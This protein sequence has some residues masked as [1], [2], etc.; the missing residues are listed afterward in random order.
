MEE[1]NA[2]PAINGTAPAADIFTGDE[3]S[4]EYWQWKSKMTGMCLMAWSSQS[5]SQKAGLIAA[6]VAGSASNVLWGGLT[7]EETESPYLTPASVFAQLTPTYGK[8]AATDE[9]VIADL[10]RLRQDGK[11]AQKYTEEF[12]AVATKGKL[13]DGTRRGLYYGG[14][15]KR[16]RTLMVGKEFD[17]LSSMIETAHEIDDL[18]DK[19]KAAPSPNAGRGRGGFRGRGRGGR[20]GYGA[21]GASEQEGT[22]DQPYHTCYACNEKGHRSFNCPKNGGGAKGTT[23]G[24]AREAST[25]SA[26]Y[27]QEDGQKAPP[28]YDSSTGARRARAYTP[29]H[30]DFDIGDH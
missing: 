22:G 11:R 24:K 2:A 15:A 8:K 25:S 26:Q 19:P 4:P 21:R 30:S 27:G 5:A 12:M 16:I 7:G 10:S 6:R 9:S 1:D 20:G 17:S 13:S 23:Q 18:V 28:M 29:S 3:K 14:L